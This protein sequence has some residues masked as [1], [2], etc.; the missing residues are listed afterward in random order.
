MSNGW[1][2]RPLRACRRRQ[3]LMLRRG[4]WQLQLPLTCRLLDLQLLP[5]SF[6]T[7]VPEQALSRFA[8]VELGGRGVAAW[9][10]FNFGEKFGCPGILPGS[11]IAPI[12][13]STIVTTAQMKKR[14]FI[15]VLPRL[16]R[17]ED[18]TTK[19]CFLETSC[20]TVP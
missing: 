19:D 17:R 1:G 14:F 9:A 20:W 10:R 6:P 15:I 16:T 11:A 12:G 7:H 5:A 2:G 3:A 13:P 4:Y 18:I 8:Q